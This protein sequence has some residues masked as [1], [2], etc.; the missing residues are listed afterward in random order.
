M[1][2]CFSKILKLDDVIKA[3][4]YL[5]N[6]LL[7]FVFLKMSTLISFKTKFV[8]RCYNP[9]R[10]QSARWNKVDFNR[11]DRRWKLEVDILL[12]F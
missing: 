12:P 1:P 5:L 3:L 4:G 2:F 10:K 6:I 11:H 8:F 9:S 7:K